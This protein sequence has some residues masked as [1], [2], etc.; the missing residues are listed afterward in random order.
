MAAQLDALLAHLTRALGDRMVAV[1]TYGSDFARGAQASQARLLVLV[2]DLDAAVLDAILP[3]NAAA[4]AQHVHLRLDTAVHVLRCA[5]V[6]PIFAL[7]LLETRVLIYGSDALTMLAVQPEHLVLRLEQALRLAHRKLLQGYLET[8]GDPDIAR[9][10]RALIR[11]LMPVMR[12]L[13]IVKGLELPAGSSPDEVV[14]RV[15]GRVCPQ[16]QELW[17]RLIRFADF[18]DSLDHTE[19]VA[20]YGDALAGFERLVVA[21]DRRD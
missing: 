9:Q 19:L 17:R 20:L 16:D 6:L 3:P 12:G 5:D 18:M 15:I 1:Y 10:L 2:D 8:Q 13:A 4:R 7:E 14:K 21:V 11:R